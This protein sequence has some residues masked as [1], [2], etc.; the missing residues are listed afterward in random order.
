MSRRCRFLLFLKHTFLVNLNCI[1][2]GADSLI[3][4]KNHELFVDTSHKV[5][6]DKMENKLKI[7]HHTLI[8]RCL[9]VAANSPKSTL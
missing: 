7:N 9:F 2:G 1:I 6:M 5:P 8:I 3:K 4:K